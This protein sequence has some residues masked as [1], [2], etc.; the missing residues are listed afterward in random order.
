MYK[1]TKILQHKTVN[2]IARVTERNKYIS[3]TH[4]VYGKLPLG[5]SVL[6]YFTDFSSRGYANV[7]QQK[8]VHGHICDPFINELSHNTVRH[9]PAEPSELQML[10]NRKFRFQRFMLFVIVCCT[11]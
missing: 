2:T 9:F 1:E 6:C 7:N 5:V 11:G 4:P 8:Q 3:P 10:E